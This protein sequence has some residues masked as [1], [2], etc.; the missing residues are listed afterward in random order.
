MKQRRWYALS[1]LRLARKAVLASF[2]VGLGLCETRAQSLEWSAAGLMLLD[3][4]FS[5]GAEVGPGLSATVTL[6]PTR[7]VSYFALASVARTDFPVGLDELHRN[8]GAAAVGV[9]LAPPTEGPR[10]GF[11]LGLGVIAWDDVSETDAGFRS[12]ANAEEMIVP[13]VELSI[14]VGSSWRMTVAARDQMSG[15]WYAVF[16][17]SEYGLSHRIIFSVGLGSG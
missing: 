8:F 12:S 4:E 5:D 9:R 11:T 1:L 7:L 16:D 13:G 14:P 17:P 10:L 6:V 3:T 2:V 15:W